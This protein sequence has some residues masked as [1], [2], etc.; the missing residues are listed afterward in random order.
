[1]IRDPSADAV[2]A[3]PGSFSSANAL[4]TRQC[5][6]QYFICIDDDASNAIHVA[7]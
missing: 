4:R 5:V 2:S 1:M 6:Q 7:F 3:R